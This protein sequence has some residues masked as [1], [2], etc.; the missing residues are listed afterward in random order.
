MAATKIPEQPE[1]G[2]RLAYLADGRLHTG[3]VKPY[4]RRGGLF[5]VQDDAEPGQYRM[6]LASECVPADEAESL[7]AEWRRR[8][9]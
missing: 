2:V 3:T 6:M 9:G 7:R 4:E 5:P 8:V 1:P